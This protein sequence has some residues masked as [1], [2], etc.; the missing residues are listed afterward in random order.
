M[1]MDNNA[2]I[3]HVNG[4]Q[5]Q[6]MH[7]SGGMFGF[8]VSLDHVQAAEPQFMREPRLLFLSARCAI[9]FLIDSLRPPQVWMPSY[10]CCSMIDAVDQKITALKFFPIGYDLEITSLDWLD[11]LIPGS[12]VVLIDYFGF[13]C[14][15]HVASEVRAGALC[16]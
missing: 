8:E 14:D 6:K 15:D 3:P 12:L 13:P 2:T 10:L 4:G 11:L 7:I 16:T 1:T 5:V 9:Q